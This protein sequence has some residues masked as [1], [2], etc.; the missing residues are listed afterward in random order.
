MWGAPVL[1][2]SRDKLVPFVNADKGWHE[3]WTKG[4]NP[5]DIPH[6]FRALLTGPPGCSKSTTAKNLLI[7]ADPPFDRVIIVHAA[8][9]I[10]KE[11]DDVKEGTTDE[12]VILT[13]E[14]PPVASF[15]PEID[16]DGAEFWPKTLLIIDDLDLRALNKV[17]KTNLNRLLG[18]VSTHCS[19]SVIVCTQ[20]PFNLKADNRRCINLYVIWRSPDMEALAMMASKVG[21]KNLQAL[22]DKYC[23]NR[24]DSIWIDTTVDTPFPMRLNGFTPI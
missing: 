10:T 6:P 14:I 17:A 15:E 13:A 24:R 8:P 20:D 18:Y 5:L 9:D 4:R 16:A 3:K 11:Y 19:V 23:K 12:H 22:F 1:G 2:G 21:V 7:R